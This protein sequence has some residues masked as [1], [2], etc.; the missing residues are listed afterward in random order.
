MMITK[1]GSDI[2]YRYCLPKEWLEIMKDFKHMNHPT[3]AAFEELAKKA[4]FNPIIPTLQT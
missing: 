3:L 4:S 2:V 1:H